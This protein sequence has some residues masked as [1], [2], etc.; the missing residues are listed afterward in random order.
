[1]DMIFKFPVAY[2]C[3][4]SVISNRDVDYGCETSSTFESR[5]VT[6]IQACEVVFLLRS[7]Q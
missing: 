3:C 1:M 5:I 4:Q 7:L 2:T 6:N